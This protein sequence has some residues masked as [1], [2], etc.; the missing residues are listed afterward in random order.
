[1]SDQR[2]GDPRINGRATANLWPRRSQRRTHSHA[3]CASGA[4]NKASITPSITNS[5]FGFASSLGSLSTARTLRRRSFKLPPQRFLS[6]SWNVLSLRYFRRYHSRCRRRFNSLAH[7]SRPH[8]FCLC[9]LR[10]HLRYVRPQTAHSAFAP[11]RL[12]IFPASEEKQHATAAIPKW[13]TSEENPNQTET[14]GFFIEAPKKI[15]PGAFG[16]AILALLAVN[17]T[18]ILVAA[19]TSV[20]AV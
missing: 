1:M 3:V 19:T 14:G 16:Y 15:P 4:S 10:R 8:A 11:D 9:T 13:W 2:C 18:S 17:K 7:A 12:A 5:R 6:V 20:L